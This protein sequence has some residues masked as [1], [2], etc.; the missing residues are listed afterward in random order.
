MAN[1]KI[2]AKKQAQVEELAKEIKEANK[3]E[4]SCRIIIPMSVRF[5]HVMPPKR[6]STCFP[7]T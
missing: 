4:T 1:E 5:P 2:I 6:C 7:Q 3:G